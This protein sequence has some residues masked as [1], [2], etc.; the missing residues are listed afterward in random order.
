[1]DQPR[2]RPGDLRRPRRVWVGLDHVPHV[3]QDVRDTELVQEAVERHVVVQ[4]VAVVHDD[5]QHPG[6]QEQLEADQ[7][8]PSQHEQREQPGRH[9]EHVPCPPLRSDLHGCLVEA[10]DLLGR[11]PLLD[12]P[13][14]RVDRLRPGG[15]QAVHPAGGHLN[16]VDLEEQLT[17][18]LDRYVR[19]HEQ[20]QRDRPDLRAVGHRRVEHLGRPGRY[21]TQPAAAHDPVQV[22][23]G[24][25]EL[26]AGDVVGL[27]RAGDPG[28]RAVGDPG[29]AGAVPDREMPL[30][31]V[32]NLPPGQGQPV[33]A[34]LLAP[35]PLPPPPPH[36]ARR[37]LRDVRVC[38]LLVRGVRVLRDASTLWGA[39]SRPGPVSWGDAALP[40]RRDDGQLCRS[41]C[42]I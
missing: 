28:D 10:D 32:R 1:M 8:T 42:P 27:M 4:A 26:D 2:E 14:R 29:A 30:D 20:V 33:L 5:T 36:P 12:L 21:M 19:A 18:P 31:P 34:R 3:P 39:R 35:L 23:L 15:E 25:S 9:R 37:L 16:L 40:S 38:D 11:D 41:A 13:H 17:D 24:H 7:V 6:E 22:V